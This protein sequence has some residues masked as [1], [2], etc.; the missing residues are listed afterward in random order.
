MSDRSVGIALGS[1]TLFSSKTPVAVNQALK[2]AIIVYARWNKDEQTG[3]FTNY[4]VMALNGED[5]LNILYEE[6]GNE[7][8]SVNK[9][10]LNEYF[11]KFIEAEGKK[12]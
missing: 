2:G 1:K 10:E 9:Y 3:M 5:Y 6:L 7:A 11:L 8:Q 12:K 4:I